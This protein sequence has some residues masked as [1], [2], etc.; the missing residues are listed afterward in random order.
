V[1]FE[2]GIHPARP[3]KSLTREA[4]DRLWGIIRARLRQA[5]VDGRILSVVAAG[6]DRA[7]VAEA[8]TR[9]VYKQA[10]CRRCGAAVVSW[11]L[12]GRM[13]YACPVCQVPRHP[14]EGRTS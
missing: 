9:W 3:A 4:F 1:L 10:R 14:D 7:T 8:E 5:V 13:V 11:Q 12:G 2:A 6:Q